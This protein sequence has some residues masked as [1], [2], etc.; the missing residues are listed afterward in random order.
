MII[1]QLISEEF[2][3][4]ILMTSNVFLFRGGEYFPV[5]LHNYSASLFLYKNPAA[6]SCGTC[7]FLSVHSNRDNGLSSFV[8][9]GTM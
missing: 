5:T 4:L 6:C 8:S 7:R 1:F 2:S 3:D 9:S